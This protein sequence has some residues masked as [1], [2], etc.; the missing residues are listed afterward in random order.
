MKKLT[1]DI[2]RIKKLAG[3]TEGDVVQFE[4]RKAADDEAMAAARQANDMEEQLNRSLPNLGRDKRLFAD[5]N[6]QYSTIEVWIETEEVTTVIDIQTI[7]KA[8]DMVQESHFIGVQPLSNGIK[9][10]FTMER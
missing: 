1:D 4:P 2:Q 8:I 9:L 3:I 5:Y 10:I 7:G 6:E